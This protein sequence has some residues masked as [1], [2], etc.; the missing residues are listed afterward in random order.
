MCDYHDGMRQE[1]L[2]TVDG[3]VLGMES[4]LCRGVTE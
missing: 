1:D 2:P 3:A 4:V